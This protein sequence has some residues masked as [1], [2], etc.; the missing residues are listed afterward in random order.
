MV[1]MT[2]N[3]AINLPRCL[4]VADRFSE[5]FVVDSASTDGTP[6]LARA[7]GARVVPFVWNGRYPK[8]K[9]WC[10]DH[11]PLSQDWVLFVDADERPTPGLLDELARLFAQ[12]PRH[13]AYWIDGRP[14]LHGRPLRFGCWN[15]KLALLDRRR[16]VFPVVAD[17]D[18]ATMWEV[19]GHYQPSVAGS[20][21]RLRHPMDHADGKPLS[22]WF[23]RHNRYSDWEAAL[24]ADGRMDRLIDGERSG[25]RWLK[26]LFQRAPLRPWL[27]FL[28]A[29]LWR[30][31][32]LDGRAGLDHALFRAFYYWQIGVKARS[33]H[34]SDSVSLSPPNAFNRSKVRLRTPGSS[35]R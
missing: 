3:E 20:L 19:E 1:V 2:R 5:C 9:Q 13:A 22:A 4:S 23:D 10:L 33:L 31:G 18:V 28:H 32:V 26:R 24:R 35:M 27:A 12:G 29:Y 25:R 34:S 15:R 7:L 6:A 11:L 14:V 30:L 16:A 8:K 21:G 17:L